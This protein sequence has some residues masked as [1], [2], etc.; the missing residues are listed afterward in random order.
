MPLQGEPG[1]TDGAVEDQRVMLALDESARS[2]RDRGHPDRRRSDVLAETDR[3]P[4]RSAR[5]GVRLAG[6]TLG[7][8]LRLAGA[9]GDQRG[10]FLVGI[11]SGTQAKHRFRAGDVVQGESVPVAD[12][13]TEP[14]DFYKTV[15]LSPDA[16]RASGLPHRAADE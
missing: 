2:G 7:Y 13:R 15:R 8:A 16:A 3:D 12:P 6:H 11:G 10:E 9:I 1:P 14:V 5:H 4:L